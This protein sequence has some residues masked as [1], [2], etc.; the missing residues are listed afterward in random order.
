[1]SILPVVALLGITVI[2]GLV[3][4]TRQFRGLRNKPVMIGAH[5]LLGAAAFEPLAVA[6]QATPG[7]PTAAGGYGMA[8]MLLIGLALVSG[9][10]RAL[11]VKHKPAASLPLLALHATFAAS[12][13]VLA[14]VVAAQLT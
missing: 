5:V 11:I 7:G 10:V 9:L 13:L 8:T 2:L 12:A 3:M 4:A 14:V 1:M 6:L